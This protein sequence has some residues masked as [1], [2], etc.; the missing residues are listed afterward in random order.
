MI[1]K[2]KIL[3]ITVALFLLISIPSK[4]DTGILSL[5]IGG[6]YSYVPGVYSDIINDS[7]VISLYSIP[8]SYQWFYIDA[9][10]SFS[11]YSLISSPK[12][13]YTPFRFS[14]GPGI[15]FPVIDYLHIFLSVNFQSIIV[16]L[17]TNELGTNQTIYKPGIS[18]KIGAI[19]PVYKGFRLKIGT[20]FSYFDL[21]SKVFLNLNFYAGIAYDFNYHKREIDDKKK[22]IILEKQKVQDETT[23]SL[24]KLIIKADD[25]F[26]KKRVSS[27]YEIYKRIL[28]IDPSNKKAQKQTKR[29]RKI[30]DTFNKAQLY[31]KR[32]RYYYALQ[33]YISIESYLPK[34]A[35]SLYNL[36]KKMY[37]RIKGLLKKAVAAYN[38]KEY[39]LSIYYLRQA[40]YIDPNNNTVKIYLPRAIKR[41]NIICF[42]PSIPLY[43]ERI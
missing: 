24:Y 39:K 37:F 7:F 41:Y 4:A 34:A 18:V 17:R 19:F 12:S 25:E 8:Y 2:I 31:E 38:K 15:V 14:F 35:E 32:G 27:A 20:E 11:V 28:I 21:T 13:L 43:V 5:G 29:I 10:F 42:H 23:V 9:E 40:S 33:L 1:M 22:N 26:A 36:R 16:N 30:L 3:H 6:G